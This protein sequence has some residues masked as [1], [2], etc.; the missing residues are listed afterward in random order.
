MADK[1]WKFC[2]LADKFGQSGSLILE[3]GIDY[4]EEGMS[5]NMIPTKV[6]SYYHDY[7]ESSYYKIFPLIWVGKSWN[8][9]LV[10]IRW[11]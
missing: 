6:K 4:N 8:M 7:V 1:N 9:I 3:Y 11:Q 5:G 2:Q 10:T